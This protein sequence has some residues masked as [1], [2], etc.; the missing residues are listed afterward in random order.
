[1]EQHDGKS[2]L[3]VEEGNHTG[4]RN[5]GTSGPYLSARLIKGFCVERLD[6]HFVLGSCGTWQVLWVRGLQMFG[7]GISRL[8][9]TWQPSGPNSSST[10]LC[11]LTGDLDRR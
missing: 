1:M 9:D 6:S 10:Q 2:H 4:K 5:P 8:Q 11:D 7:T 3:L